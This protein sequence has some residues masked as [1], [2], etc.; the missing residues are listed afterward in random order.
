MKDGKP[1]G[2]GEPPDVSNLMLALLEHDCRWNQGETAEASGV[3]RSQISEYDRGERPVPRNVMEK[4]AGAANF[5]VTLLDPAQRAI[6]SFQVARQGRSRAGRVAVEGAW[7]ELLTLF[8][9]AADVVLSPLHATR[10]AHERLAPEDREEGAELARR[11][12]RR[13]PREREMLLEEAEEYRGWAVSEQLAMQ[14]LA[15]APNQPRAA[16]ELAKLALRIAGRVPGEATWRWRLEG[17]ALAYMANARRAGGDLPAAERD[18]ARALKLWGAGAPGDPG[19]LNP[20]VLPWIEAGLRMDQRQLIDARERIEEALR[21]DPGGLRGKILI[22]KSNILRL[23]DDAAGATAVLHEAATLIDADR[24]PR[25]AFGVRFNLLA[26]LC[27]LERAAEAEPRLPEV[28]TL[29]ERLGQ[30]H[31]LTRVVWLEGKVAAG[32]GRAAEA[33]AAFEQVL[34]KWRAEELA[35]ECALVSLDLALV[36]LK[37]GRTAEVRELAAGMLWIFRTQGVHREALAA[38]KLFCDAARQE[39]ATVDL[40]RRVSQYL[41]RA[42]H[43][44]DLP[45]EPGGAEAG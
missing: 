36:H 30:E 44:P 13:T 4:V 16:L 2:K 25:L 21:F 31:D 1:R 3:A 11:L 28:R 23:L 14:S 22:T 40:A 18:L 35:Y 8:G 27:H 6:R 34:R 15:L 45:F 9:R 26:A 5:P 19:L 43:D 42:Q 12:A 24:D 38:L 37:A 33:Q 10:E 39:A 17:H 41:E 20:A 29:A 7:A 32:M